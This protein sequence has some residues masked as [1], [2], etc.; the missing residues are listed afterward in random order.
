MSRSD[1]N[2]LSTAKGLMAG[3]LELIIN[4]GS[5]I[6]CQNTRTV[7][8]NYLLLWLFTYAKTE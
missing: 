5:Y 7:S 8:Y 3:N 2:I 6:N 1:F 4:D